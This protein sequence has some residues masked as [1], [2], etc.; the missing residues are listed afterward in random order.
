[1]PD[2]VALAAVA[3]RDVEIT[4]RII[5]RELLGREPLLQQHKPARLA[6]A[7]QTEFPKP[8]PSGQRAVRG[9]RAPPQQWPDHD[10]S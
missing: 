5:L 1:M 4:L 6:L 8:L 9:I 2:P 7:V 10:Q 3:T